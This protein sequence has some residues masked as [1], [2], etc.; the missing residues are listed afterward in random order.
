MPDIH[1]IRQLHER[2]GWSVRRIA[3]ELHYSRKTVT[4]YLKRT[5]EAPEVPTYVRTQPAPAPQLGPYHP[6]IRQWLEADRTAPRKQRHTSRRIWQRLRDEYGATVSESTV[7]HYVARLR[8]DLQP[9]TAPVFFDLV[10]DPGEAAQVDWGEA[11]IVVAGQEYTAQIFCMRLAYSGAAFVQVFP[12]QR[13]EAFLAAHVA[14][15][16]FFGGIPHHIIYDNLTTA[17]HRILHGRGRELT[18]RFAEFA[19]H[20]VY[21]PIFATPASGWEKG[22]AKLEVM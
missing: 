18:A 9:E 7:R 21:E 3:R 13:L 14:A 4:K 5:E 17:V 1:S 2:Q 15:F 19:A 20:Y 10:F 8:R 12:H 6:V 22:Y 11:K 16:D